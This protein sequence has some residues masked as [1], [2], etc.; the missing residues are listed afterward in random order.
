[1]AVYTVVRVDAQGAMTERQQKHR[2]VKQTAA[3]LLCRSAA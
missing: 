1:L 3:A 2:L